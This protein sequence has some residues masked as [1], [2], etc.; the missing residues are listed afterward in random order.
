MDCVAPISDR[1]PSVRRTWCLTTTIFRTPNIGRGHCR[2]ASGAVAQSVEAELAEGDGPRVIAEFSDYDELLNGLRLR[3]ADLNLSG[4]Q[5]DCISGLT[6]RYAQKLLGP[7]Q[8]RRLGAI[9]LGPFLGALAVRGWLVEDKAAV[10]R[11]K[12]R[13]TPRQSNY[14]RPTYTYLTITNRKWAQI[15]KLGRKARW[16]R[17]SKK[18]RSD[19]MRAL[20]LKRWQKASP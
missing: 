8:I 7:N 2:G 13:I 6:S 19:F 11:L 1:R 17:L 14:I 5:I 3:A 9:S 12:T 20:V 15:Q 4:E 16:G 18:Q 10:E